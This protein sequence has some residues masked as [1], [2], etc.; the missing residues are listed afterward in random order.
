SAL[1]DLVTNAM[2]SWKLGKRLAFK[3]SLGFT[4]LHNDESII[5]PS[6]MYNPDYGMDAESSLSKFNTYTRQ[7]Y[8]IEPQINWNWS[9]G[10]S[11][12]DILAGSTFQ[13]QRSAKLTQ[14]GKGY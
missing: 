13:Q 3:T 7:S 5:Y 14:Q 2:L 8:T 12:F 9:F 1:N 4:D 6:T 10:N 11:K